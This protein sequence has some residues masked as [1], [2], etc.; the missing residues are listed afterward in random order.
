MKYRFI[1]LEGIDGSGKST[2]A[3]NLQ[4]KIGRQFSCVS[5]SEP[6][7]LNIWGKELRRI[8]KTKSDIDKKLSLKLRRLFKKDRLW[9]IKN[10]I[11]PALR[12]KKVVILDRYYFSTAAYQANSRNEVDEILNEYRND[13]GILVPDCVLYLR[14]LPEETLHRVEQ[15]NSQKEIFEHAGILKKIHEHYEYIQSKFA[16]QNNFISI[17]ARM[18]EKELTEKALL[19]LGF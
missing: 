13:T 17:D 14:I 6:T 7:E 11:N 4:K 9:D 10:R 18:N 1:V 16:A 5:I 19:K 3:K 15:R 8:L 12:E 2:L